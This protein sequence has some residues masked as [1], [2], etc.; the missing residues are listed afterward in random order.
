MQGFRAGR[1]KVTGDM[2][3]FL[4]HARVNAEPGFYAAVAGMTTADPYETASLGFDLGLGIVAVDGGLKIARIRADGSVSLSDDLTEGTPLMF[5]DSVAG[6]G[7][8]RA[9]GELEDLVNAPDAREADFQHFFERYPELLT[10][11]DFVR[12]HPHLVLRSNDGDLIPDFI[13]EPAN[14]ARLSEVLEIKLPRARPVVG[15]ERRPRPSAELQR[16]AAQIREYRDFFDQESNRRKFE[17]E[18]GLRAYRPS[19]ILIIGTRDAVTPEAFRLASESI[20]QVTIFTYDDVL[21]RASARR[22][23]IR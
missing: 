7:Y 22:R 6:M 8:A 1:V 10:G 3:K 21:H 23:L 11:D 20:P 12:A 2:P 18:Y 5:L 13:L 19:G 16:A 15:G 14:P 9:A 17:E 4:D